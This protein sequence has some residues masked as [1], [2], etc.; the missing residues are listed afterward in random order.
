MNDR[1]LAARIPRNLN[2]MPCCA[3]LF[4][5]NDFLAP[6][7]L[8]LVH[9]LFLKRVCT[10]SPSVFPSCTAIRPAL[11]SIAPLTV[12]HSMAKNSRA[13]LT[14]QFVQIYSA[15]SAAYMTARSA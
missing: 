9:V 15:Y 12:N 14:H 10:R 6:Q 1:R 11:A 13:L 3:F 8:Q 7:A 2:R 4:P 5:L